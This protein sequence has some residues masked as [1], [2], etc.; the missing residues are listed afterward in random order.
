ME[1]NNPND[2]NLRRLAENLKGTT[3]Y[4][5]IIEA[6]V[7]SIQAIEDRQCNDGKITIE[8]LR[9]E[10]SLMMPG[11]GLAPIIGLE[12]ADNGAGFNDKNK[13]S[14]RRYMDDSKIDIGGKGIGRLTFLK[15]FTSINI[16]SIFRNK[17]NSLQRRR[18]LFNNEYF[19]SRETV[20]DLEEQEELITRVRLTGVRQKYEDQLHLK[21]E[22]VA[23]KV[24]ECLLYYFAD[25]SYE[26]PKI[27]VLDKSKSQAINLNAY[28]D[29]HQEVSELYAGPHVIKSTNGANTYKFRVAIYKI[30]YQDSMNAVYLC[31]DRRAVSKTNLT[32]YIP[33]IKNDSLLKELRDDKAGEEK[34]PVN[35]RIQAYVYGDYLNEHV[36]LERNS[37]AFQTS[38][39]NQKS[40]FDLSDKDI[41][42]SVAENLVYQKLK[43]ILEPEKQKR[44]NKVYD[45]VDKKAPY[46]KTLVNDLMK[47]MPHDLS[48]RSLE[49]KFSEISTE[50]RLES[51][52]TMDKARTSTWDEFIKNKDAIIDNFQENNLR[53]LGLYVDYRRHMLELFSQSLERDKDS[54]TYS[55]ED[56]IHDII[57]PRGTDSDTLAYQ[58]HNLWMIDENLVFSSFVSSDQKIPKSGKTPDLAVYHNIMFREEND[59]SNPVTV[60][61]YKRPQ[62]GQYYKSEDP[63]GQLCKYIQAIRKGKDFKTPQ[64]RD[65]RL[66]TILLLTDSWFAI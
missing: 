52:S 60:F 47:S 61:E 6:V 14:F 58:N 3:I 20:D 39:E 46:Y 41:E 19:V 27:S 32:N 34:Q 24:F 30:Y 5:P 55:K 22:T 64:G 7:N 11:K 33:E 62:R 10:Q 44:R 59:P 35:Y 63:I 12:I 9:S 29:T 57:F 16:D 1:N 43:D 51:I 42:R 17:Q 45:Y 28:I 53:Y 23:R 18:F 26:C 56:V 38:S 8:L 13:V 50:R 15:Y 54:D 25:S 31:A 4:T 48:D 36:D 21:A 66:T 40:L 65:I 2:I 37:F 49:I